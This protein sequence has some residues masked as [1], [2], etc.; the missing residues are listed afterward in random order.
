MEKMSWKA[1]MVTT[2]LLCLMVGTLF[3]AAPNAETNAGAYKPIFIKILGGEKPNPYGD[4]PTQYIH[5][6]EG[7]SDKY[8]AIDLEK[9]FTVY[10]EALEYTGIPGTSLGNFGITQ[11]LP[12]KKATQLEAGKK[13]L[14]KFYIGALFNPNIPL[15]LFSK[16]KMILEVSPPGSASGTRRPAEDKNEVEINEGV[17]ALIVTQGKVWVD[18]ENIRLLTDNEIGA[19]WGPMGEQS[20]SPFEG[21]TSPLKEKQDTLYKWDVKNRSYEKLAVLATEY[22]REPKSLGFLDKFIRNLIMVT[23]EEAISSPAKEILK[24]ALKLP[25]GIALT[26]AEAVGKSIKESVGVGKPLEEFYK[27]LKKHNLNEYNLFDITFPPSA[28]QRGRSHNAIVEIPIEVKETGKEGKVGFYLYLNG[29]EQSVYHEWETG[30]PLFEAP[31]LPDNGREEKY[32]AAG[33]MVLVKRGSFQ[34]GS[35]EGYSDEKPVHTVTLT[36]DYWMGKYEVTFDEYDAYTKATGKGQASDYSS[37]AGYNMGRGT[38]PVINVSWNDA[39]A[40]CNWLSEKEGIAK[41]YDSNGNLLDRNGRT[42][43][44]ITKVQ[45][46]RLPT[47]AEWEYAARGGTDSKG[48]KYAGSDDPNEVGWY[49]QN[50]GD[51]WLPGT[52]S[53]RDGDKI[54]ANKNKTHP[55][56]QKKAN[57]LG[58]Y[59]M[60]GNVWELCHDWWGGYA[61]TT[62]TNPTGPGGGSYRVYRGGS[63]GS[64]G[65]YCRAAYPGYNTPASSFSNLGFRVVRTDF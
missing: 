51:K 22:F 27:T 41:A 45:G 32:P 31:E 60:S 28:E 19:W 64:S 52:D 6:R 10:V 29:G 11:E 2:L 7:Y 8:M 44:D 55:V 17:L 63:W 18:Y 16:T 21:K 13:Y 14:L 50:A 26:I 56:G 62:Q 9:A 61:S 58:L 49:W 5:P 33:G 25:N 34:M 12:V 36:Y 23:G 15:D 46:Y 24:N 65:Q 54:K 3:S 43:T 42:T 35:N 47:E 1:C 40:Y 4:E 59:D 53:D 48:Y 20:T 38:R 39:I 57:E 30:K 37:W